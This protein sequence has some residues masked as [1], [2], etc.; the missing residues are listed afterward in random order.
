MNR[1]ALVQWNPWWSQKHS[2]NLIDRDIKK[3]L[4]GWLGRREIIGIIGARRSGKTSLMFLII[5]HLLKKTNPKNILFIKCDDDRVEKEG[6][7]SKSV[8]RYYDMVS[9]KGN[10]Y[11][12]IDEIQEVPGWE[13]T[14]KR[15]YDIEKGMKFFISGSNFS[16]LK[17]DMTQKMAG[18]LAYFEIYPFSFK[19]IVTREINTSDKLQ[20]LS[21]KKEIRHM[22]FRYMEFGG[23]PEVVLENDKTKK[24]QILQFYYDTIVY[25]DII[26]RRGIR[27]TA[28]LDKMI[29]Y[30]LQNISNPAS[31]SKTGKRV[32]LSTDSVVEYMKHLQDAFFLFSVSMFSFSV[33]KQ[34]INP[35]KV[36]CID[37]GLRNIKGFRFSEDYGR[38]AEN[39][40]FLELLRRNSSNPL[41]KVYYWR[42]NKHEVD[43]VTKDGLKVKELIQVCWDIESRKTK[44]REVCGL[45]EAMKE[46]KLRKATIVTESKDGGETVSGKRI[47]YV[48]LWKWL[49]GGM[50]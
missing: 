7:V 2:F 38:L 41:F 32:F 44:Q 35:K 4:L 43:F 49:L 48:P 11:I 50:M 18:R 29:N 47:D 9:P 34:E 17:E 12:F 30:F 26:K 27:N 13:N 6:L 22:L 25:R 28:K 14:L 37:N 5:E 23:F 36:Y 24:G 46:L 33:K 20:A 42:N 3:E 40:V 1:E 39:T 45:L 31:F 15:M 19:E 8:E 10:I 21:K 16:V